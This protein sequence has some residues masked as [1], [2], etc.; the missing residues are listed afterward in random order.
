MKLSQVFYEIF[1]S[2]AQHLDEIDSTQ[3]HEIDREIRLIDEQGEST[4]ISW[5]SEPV[6]YSVG[7]SKVSFFDEPIPVIQDM[8]NSGLWKA[9]VGKDVAVSFV[10]KH[11]QV[12]EITNDDNDKV[13]CWTSAF[14]EEGE[15]TLFI[16]PQTPLTH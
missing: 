7:T 4:F 6:Q 14:D 3:I 11:H 9:L 13:Y 16:S 1:E 12:L 10:D 8:S 2:D 5:C 15:D